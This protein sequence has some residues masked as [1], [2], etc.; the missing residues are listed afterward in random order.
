MMTRRTPPRNRRAAPRFLD[1]AGGLP[2]RWRAGRS[3]ALGVLRIAGSGVR[4]AC[5]SL[6]ALLMIG[7]STPVAYQRPT[8]ELPGHWQAKADA[9]PAAPETAIVWDRWWPEFGSDELNSLAAAALAGNQ[10]LAAAQQRVL[11]A[12]ALVDS[13]ASASA[14]TLDAQADASR[15]RRSGSGTSTTLGLGVSAALDLDLNGA[16]ARAVDA[17]TGRVQQREAA[18]ETL[19]A[20]L[21]V[22]LSEQY[23][24]ILSALDRLEI[25][26]ANIANAESLLTL[27]KSRQQAGAVASLEVV[28][29]EGL[30]ATLRAGVAPLEQQRR[31]A[32]AALAV[33]TGRA[34]QGFGVQATSL[35]AVRL[36]AL[37]AA[38]P[39]QLLERHPEVRQAEAELIVAHADLNAARSAWLPRGR[40]DVGAALESATLAALFNG[41]TVIGSLGAGM[42]APLID[43]GRIRAQLN[44]ATARRDEVTHLYRQAVLAALRDVEDRLSALRTL[45]EQ[46]TQQQ[47]VVEFAQA[48]LRMA[49][50]RYRNG[51]TDY[52][53]VLDAQRVLLAAQ[54]SQ[55]ITHLAR[56][57]QT[58]GL[59]RALGGGVPPIGPGNLALAVSRAASR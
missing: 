55:A 42:L 23:F 29:Q 44:A 46:A 3:P 32:L 6:V 28:R 54:D 8:V 58:L 45:A 19:G 53:T 16:S 38:L 20:S 2:A 40:I 50:L 31:S 35:S 52:A 25:A 18:R 21:L 33:L 30:V 13:A 39:V 41:A 5:A 36:P 56:Y 14:P 4:G 26:R 24:R 1:P 7:C 9:A 43:G 22:D 34:P 12:R 57:S 37:A 27:L 10:E 11:L 49:D 51:A 15:T 59:V 47:R 48:S 17:A